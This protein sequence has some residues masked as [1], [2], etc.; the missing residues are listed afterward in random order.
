MKKQRSS[1]EQ[2]IGFLKQA[3]A[4]GMAAFGKSGELCAGWLIG[5]TC[6][7]CTATRAANH[8]EQRPSRGRQQQISL[9]SFPRDLIRT[10][11]GG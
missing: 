6:H 7:P 4:G 3:E 1:E 8:R 11:V 2:I 9:Q 5:A 10:L